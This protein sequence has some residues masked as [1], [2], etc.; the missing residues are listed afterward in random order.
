MT[1]LGILIT[2]IAIAL[3]DYFSVR[4][5]IKWNKCL[6]WDLYGDVVLKEL[7]KDIKKESD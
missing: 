1:F 3:M 2:F 4:L 5:Y 6:F 7:S